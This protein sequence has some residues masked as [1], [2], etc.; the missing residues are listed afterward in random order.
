[1]QE[2]NRRVEEA[3][4]WLFFELRSLPIQTHFETRFHEYGSN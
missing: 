1:V 3:R 4:Q 2:N